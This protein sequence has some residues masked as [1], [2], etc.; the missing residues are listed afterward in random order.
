[1]PCLLFVPPL[2]GI[3]LIM[4]GAGRCL[5]SPQVRKRWVRVL[6]APAL[7]T[8]SLPVDLEIIARDI[9]C[10]T[11]LKTELLYVAP[12]AAALA[13]SAVVF[14]LARPSPAARS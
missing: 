12:I 8:V 13:L 4:V 10:E 1:M 3:I 6:V 9:A 2:I 5:R 11:V 7:L 14:F